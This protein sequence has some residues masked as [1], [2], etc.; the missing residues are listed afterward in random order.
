MRDAIDHSRRTV[1]PTRGTEMTT[2]APIPPIRAALDSM[3]DGDYE[4]LC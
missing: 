2:T 3:N 1:R 4:G